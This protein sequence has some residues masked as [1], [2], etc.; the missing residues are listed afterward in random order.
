MRKNYL[1][2]WEGE[3]KRSW[4]EKLQEDLKKNKENK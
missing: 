2:S 3:V 4:C 1:K